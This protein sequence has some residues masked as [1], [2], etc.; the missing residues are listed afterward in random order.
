MTK[1]PGFHYN[2]W[3]GLLEKVEWVTAMFQLVQK[4]PE[5]ELRTSENFL[6]KEQASG[7]R[8]V[9]ESCFTQ[10]ANLFMTRNPIKI[11]NCDKNLFQSLS[12][13]D[14]ARMVKAQ[15]MW[16]G[17]HII[18]CNVSQSWCGAMDGA[19]AFRSLLPGWS[20]QP[21]NLHAVWHWK[22]PVKV[23][24]LSLSVIPG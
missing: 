22:C 7:H 19:R 6:V 5:K 14:N 4:H 3:D 20:I 17:R 15:I 2:R 24:S 9:F 8:Q 23:L 10:I 21:H 16:R 12:V 11:T 1:C 13:E 18:F